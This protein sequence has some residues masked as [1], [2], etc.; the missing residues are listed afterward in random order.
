MKD[1]GNNAAVSVVIPTLNALAHLPALLVALRMQRPFP[2]KEILIV[3]SRSTDG[4]RDYLLGIGGEVRLIDIACFSHG[5]ARNLGVRHSTGDF[6]VFLSQ[7][8]IPRDDTWLAQLLAPF[9][10]AEVAATFS[11]QVPRPNANPM[12]RFFLDTHFPAS[13]AVYRNR[14]DNGELQFQRDVF[15]SNVSSAARRDVILQHPFDERLIMSEDQQFARDVI[16]AG[17]IVAYSPRS[18][19]DHSHN[20]SFLQVMRRY[21]DSALSLAMIFP[22]HS[23]SHAFRIGMPYLQS[24]FVMMLRKHRCALPGYLAYVCARSMG[25]FLGHYANTL[26]RFVVKRL[27]FHRYHWEQAVRFDCAPE[28]AHE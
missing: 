17:H 28:A 7:D 3:D 25:V 12:E 14:T 4:T 18:M 13:P 1:T 23:F 24:E 10:N 15:F 26:P 6:V 20:Y 22:K 21:F 2:P 11:R 8:A 27:S 19:V 9:H 16:L 5:G